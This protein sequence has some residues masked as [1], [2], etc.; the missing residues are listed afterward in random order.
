MVVPESIQ[1]GCYTHDL[2]L[3]DNDDELIR[4]TRAFVEQGLEAGD[5]VLVHSSEDRVQLLHG[6]LGSHPRLEYGLDED[7]YLSPASTLFAYQRKFVE[8]PLPTDLWVTGTVPLGADASG[9]PAWTRYESLVNEVLG[10]YAF[11]A[12]C[13]YDTHLLPASTIAAA[14]ATHLCVSTGMARTTSPDYQDPT[15]F[16]NDPLAAVPEPPALRPTVAMTLQRLE[17]LAHARELVRRS[18]VSSS[19]VA[20]DSIDGF[21]TAVNEVLVNA[22]QHGATPVRLVLWVEPAQLTCQVIDSGP[23]KADPLAGYR[24]PETEGAK[25]LWVA[26]QLC[27][28]IF[29]S[30]VP[31]RGC[32]VLLFS[33]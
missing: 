5:N 31:D 18:A 2:L 25:G 8:D 16:L 26:R 10:P 27:E 19:A 33:A 22:L 15:D 14:K 12:L 6:V 11:H 32:S 4:G 9:H 24:Y 28:D 29:V 21:V 7:L 23:G 30:N 3:H 13:T 17:H 1:R 20:R